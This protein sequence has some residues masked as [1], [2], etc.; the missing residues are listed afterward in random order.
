MLCW[1]SQCY[2]LLVAKAISHI[3]S[4]MQL[5]MHSV[6]FFFFTSSIVQNII[7]P[8]MNIFK[9][10]LCAFNWKFK[11]FRWDE[12]KIYILNCCYGG[13]PSSA[14]RW[15]LLEKQIDSLK[16]AH[17]RPTAFR[18]CVSLTVF[19]LDWSAATCFTLYRMKS[20]IQSASCKLTT[21]AQ[22]KWHFFNTFPNSYGTHFSLLPKEIATYEMKS[23]PLISALWYGLNKR[24]I[25]AVHWASVCSRER[26]WGRFR[27]V[28]AH[29]VYM[30]IDRSECP[31]WSVDV[32]LRCSSVY[33][34]FL[35]LHLN[36]LT[37]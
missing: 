25:K 12:G 9:N 19:P 35:H 28:E 10:A 31:L 23:S 5:S 7:Q 20:T 22:R 33:S 6:L 3:I 26:C 21:A 30:E 1:R 29:S 15:C 32:T 14:S 18:A 27:W 16:A 4:L 8:V 36:Y 34:L 37:Y 11:L 24:E 13:C 17:S 2:H